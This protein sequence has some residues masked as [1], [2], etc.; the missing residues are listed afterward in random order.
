MDRFGRRRACWRTQVGGTVQHDLAVPEPAVSA[1]SGKDRRGRMCV[2]K[3]H[4][5]GVER[6]SSGTAALLSRDSRV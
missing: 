6:V 1:A 3:V 2:T 4:V 5:C